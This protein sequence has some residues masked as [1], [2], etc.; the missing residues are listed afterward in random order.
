MLYNL[1][2]V[3][4]YIHQYLHSRPQA[5]R[6]QTV[7][8]ANNDDRDRRENVSQTEQE[9]RWDNGQTTEDN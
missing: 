6:N 1:I 3:L 9:M 7:S 4:I 5:R 8:Q 2:R